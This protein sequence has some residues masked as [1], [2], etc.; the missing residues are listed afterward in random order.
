MH[1]TWHLTVDHMVVVPI[2]TLFYP[3]RRL[4]RPVY[5]G[6]KVTDITSNILCTAGGYIS[7]KCMRTVEF[8]V[9]FLHCI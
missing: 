5:A 1:W 4:I 2:E 7:I 6:A 3:V 8:S 9:G